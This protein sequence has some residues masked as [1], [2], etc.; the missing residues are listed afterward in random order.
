MLGCMHAQYVVALPSHPELHTYTRTQNFC[1][2]LIHTYTKTCIVLIHT[3]I[4]EIGKLLMNKCQLLAS[5]FI[6]STQTW[7]SCVVSCLHHNQR[8]NKQQ[9]QQML[10]NPQP[11]SSSWSEVMTI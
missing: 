2:V 4:H 10:F 8:S 9:Q 6:C 7:F 3:Y 5:Y 1:I 11:A